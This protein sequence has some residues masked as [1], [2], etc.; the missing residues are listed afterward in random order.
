MNTE[1]KK[2][3]LELWDELINVKKKL[4]EKGL[5]ESNIAQRIEEIIIP[6]WIPGDW[7][8]NFNSFARELND[9]IDELPEKIAD[10]LRNLKTLCISILEFKVWYNGEE[11]VE[12]DENKYQIPANIEI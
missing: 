7:I 9:Y 4:T 2:L 3:T 11:L 8:V 12:S 10:E 6:N 1:F 5:H